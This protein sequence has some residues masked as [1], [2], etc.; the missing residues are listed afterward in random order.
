MK[1][2]NHQMIEKFI[3]NPILTKNTLG[4]IMTKEYYYMMMFIIKQY[5]FGYTLD[6]QDVMQD[7]IIKLIVSYNPIKAKTN[8]TYR[9]VPHL[10]SIT[11]S[12]CKDKYDYEKR[13]VTQNIE[14]PKYFTSILIDNRKKNAIDMDFHLLMRKLPD[15]EKKVLKL[16]KE[17]YRHKDI[18]DKLNISVEASRKRLQKARKKLRREL[19]NEFIN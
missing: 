18:A 19:R 11:H 10:F 6:A 1:Y 16:I 3:K 14:L 4:F 5:N 2:Y 7:L 9:S 17:G 12:F 8:S 15:N 13:R